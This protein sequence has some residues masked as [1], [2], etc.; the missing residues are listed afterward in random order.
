MPKYGSPRKELGENASAINQDDVLI[1]M[2]FL[3]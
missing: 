3:Y 1:I 2:S